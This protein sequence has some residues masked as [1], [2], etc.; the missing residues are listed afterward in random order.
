M[1]LISHVLGT[2]GGTTLDAVGKLPRRKADRIMQVDVASKAADVHARVQPV[3][4]ASAYVRGGK[5]ALDAVLALVLLVVFLPVMLACVVAVRLT[6][7]PKL[8]FRQGRVGKDGEV[9]WILK[10][11]T[12]RHSRRCQSVPFQGPERRKTHKHPN[13]PRLNTVGGV[14]RRLS[15]DE[16]PQ[17]VNVLKGE[18]SLVGPR[19]E[20]VE[21][22]DRYE[23]WQHQRH[24]VR[25]GLT[26]L[27][28]VSARHRMMHEATEIDLHYVARVSLRTDIGIL[29]RTVP[30]LFGLTGSPAA[31][32]NDQLEP[33]AGARAVWN[34]VGDR[35]SSASLAAE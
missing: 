20:L 16:L 4:P 29:F 35:T 8:L 31:P 13:D 21:I 18:M 19:P 33:E 9:F 14:L 24:V 34:D 26:G 7:G 1:S 12:M 11:R 3:P 17:L 32:A 10:F 28:Q 5:R 2:S 27:W 15:L 6:L 22:V 30:S 23:P 25:P